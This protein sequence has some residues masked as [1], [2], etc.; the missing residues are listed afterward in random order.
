MATKGSLFEAGAHFLEK[1]HGPK[2]L[3]FG[4]KEKAAQMR[5][6]WPARTHSLAAP[7]STRW[8]PPALSRAPIHPFRHSAGAS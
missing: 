6:A 2:G 7:K 5:Q 4:R 8:P 3:E 1:K